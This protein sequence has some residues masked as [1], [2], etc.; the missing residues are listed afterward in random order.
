MITYPGMS[1]GEA[2]PDWC[3]AA[4]LDE[5][6]KA[7]LPVRAGDLSHN[8]PAMF[9]AYARGAELPAIAEIFG[10]PPDVLE[11][12]AVAQRWGTLGERLRQEPIEADDVLSEKLERIEEN[13]RQNFA[14]AANFRTDLE[15][16]ARG[17]ADGTLK[18]EQIVK[19]KGGYDVVQVDPTPKEV[20]ALV[21]AA[22]TMS[23]ITY[24]AIGDFPETSKATRDSKHPAAGGGVH[25]QVNIPSAVSMPRTVIQEESP[26]IEN[27][28]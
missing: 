5:E 21:D 3:A 18:V 12:V 15:R 10:C 23:E 9:I 25:I 13:R 11:K 22:R 8:W 20:K 16:R 14:V 6:A 7:G 1:K 19:Y 27:E 4:I 28:A 17:L 26:I 24:R 2:I